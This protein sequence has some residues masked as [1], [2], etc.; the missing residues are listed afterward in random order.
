MT[1]ELKS[2]PFCGGEAH[3]THWENWMLPWA[4]KVD[5]KEGCLLGGIDWPPRFLSEEELVD[6][7][8]TRTPTPAAPTSDNP[9]GMYCPDC[10]KA[11]LSH[12]AH[13]E[14]CG[15]MIPMEPAA[16]QDDK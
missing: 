15:G 8:N 10:R 4:V 16:P 9:S 5:H 11:G 7:W 13:P 6:T 2:C 14:T 12:Y 1:D 3:A